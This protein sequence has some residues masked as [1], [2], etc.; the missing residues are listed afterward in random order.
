MSL[1]IK[2]PILFLGIGGVGSRMAKES[3]NIL[4]ADYYCINNDGHEA[5]QESLSI[6]TG[7]VINPSVNLIR[8]HAYEKFE[9]I[10]EKIS[11]YSTI[12]MFTNMAG[13][14]GPAISP[15]ISEAC[16]ESGAT[17]VSFAIMPFRHEKER[18]FNAGIGLKRLKEGSDATIILDNDAMFECNP[19]LTP[20]Q[21]F[22][23]GNSAI[24]QIVSSLAKRG[25]QNELNIISASAKS[26]IESSLKESLK[27]LYEDAPPTGVKRTIIHVAGSNRISV[28]VLESIT[29]F[30]R[31]A[32]DE[33]SGIELSTSP[34]KNGIVMISSIQGQTK[35]D[36]YDPLDIIP[37]E[38]TLDWDT[39]ECSIDYKTEIYQLE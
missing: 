32:L 30:A 22:E 39:P 35:F 33:N 17:L 5:N 2:E 24:L 38:N 7:N 31:H 12:I 37:K 20:Q 15:I 1:E 26:S 3:K 9:K 28:G 8:S 23:I 6:K 29:H 14:N 27:M 4:D 34:E 36:S 21:C 11:S 10:F 18:I 13:K 19:E 25:I 16:Q